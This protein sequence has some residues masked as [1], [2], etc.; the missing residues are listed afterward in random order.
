MHVLDEWCYEMNEYIIRSKDIQDIAR[1]IKVHSTL[2]I[3]FFSL[4]NTI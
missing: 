1:N 4:L 2:K 3:F